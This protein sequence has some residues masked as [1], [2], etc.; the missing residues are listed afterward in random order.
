M[1]LIVKR[2]TL[3]ST[4]HTEFRTDPDILAL[5]EIHGCYGFSG[6]WSRKMHLRSYP[7]EQVAKPKNAKFNFVAERAPEADMSA[8]GAAYFAGLGSGFW[9]SPAELPVMPG[10]EIF[11]PKMSESDRERKVREW[12]LALKGLLKTV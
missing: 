11:E 3:P 5:E 6:P 8:T 4:P 2:G 9:A 10:Y 1:S 7:T 12:R